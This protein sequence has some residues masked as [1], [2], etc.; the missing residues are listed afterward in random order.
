MVAAARCGHIVEVAGERLAGL[1][2]GL[3]LLEH[4]AGPL[5]NAGRHAGN[6]GHMDAEAVGAAALDELAHK[7]DLAVD[8]LHGHVVVLDAAKRL[9]HLVELV[10]VGGKE[11][12]GVARVLVNV[13]H[14][15]P[16]YRDAVVGAGAAAQL[17]E[18]HQRAL[19]QV[20]EYRGCLGHLDHEGRL[21]QRDIVAGPHAG[22]DLVDDAYAGTLGGHIAAYLRHEGDEGRLSQQGALAGHVGARDDHHLL[23]VVAQVQAVG[24]IGLAR[25]QAPL[26][27][28]VAAG[29]DIDV[30]TVVDHG[31]VVLVVDG[32]AREGTQAVELGDE[33]RVGL[34]GGDVVG[35]GGHE[36]AE[37]AGLDQGYFLL[38]AQYFFFIFLEL[39][40]DVALGVDQRLLAHPLG[41]HLVAVGVAHLDVVAKDVVVGNLEAGYARA[42]ALLLLQAHEVVLARVGDV[43]QLVELGVDTAVDDVAAAHLGRSVGVDF[44]LDAFAHAAA[45]V[46]LLAYRGQHRLVAGAAH[47]LHGLDGLQ[48]ALELHQL[49]RGD[50]PHGHL[51]DEALDVAHQ[52]ELLLDQVAGIGVLEEIVHHVE[53]AVDGFHV[54]ERE[55]HPAVHHAGSHGRE[56]LVDDAEQAHA[57]LGHGCHQLEVAHGELVEAHVALGL[58][59]RQGGDVLDVGVLREVEIVQHG[60]RGDDGRWHVVDPEALQ[61]T[62]LEVLEQAVARSLL[63]KNPVVEL[64]GEVLAV[65]EGVGK[66]LAVAALDEHLL[67]RK[68]DQ[69]L[70]DIVGRALRGDE[71]ARR[72][73]EKGHAQQALLVEVHGSQEVVFLAVEDG[74]A[75]HHTGGD[76]L[77]DAPLHQFLGQLGVFELVAYS[78]ALA[79]AHQLGQVGVEGVVRKTGHL[80]ALGSA[81]GAARERDAQYLAGHYGIL[82]VGF[83]EVAHA[84][85]QQGI[86]VLL[87]HREIL[88][89]HG[90]GRCF[91]SHILNIFLSL[92]NYKFFT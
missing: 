10:V 61:V 62:G 72:D 50:A 25:W 6:L 85:K 14:N 75:H 21:A 13:L 36:L 31:A 45:G 38:G 76:E 83:I 58:D 28:R 16:G 66:A 73:V 91:F 7:H 84:V 74:A 19:A 27:D 43:A 82:P 67:G 69:Q 4:L 90:C 64:K 77:G 46:E 89:H 29:S 44:L 68:V 56:G 55:E 86:G 53:A 70:V 63:G 37:E 9:G 34:N 35:H 40:G 79:G 88:L 80:H 26:D 32:H 33:G 15:G 81:I 52:L 2:V 87:L 92:Q 48:G 71:L 49:A 42:L 54:L 3:E 78:H 11:G 30:E 8:F 51:G 59:A 12:L 5:D 17:V 20:V 23:V 47:A 22:E 65:A 1:V 60:S 39:L 41:G 18:E 57:V 24:H